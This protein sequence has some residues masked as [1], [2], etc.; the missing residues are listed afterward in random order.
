MGIYG[1]MYNNKSGRIKYSIL[2][3]A[4]WIR[5]NQ[6]HPKLYDWNEYPL[7]R[8][9]NIDRRYKKMRRKS[10]YRFKEW[11]HMHLSNR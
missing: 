9:G 2:K 1:S 8:Y 10:E 6:F 7:S 11:R 5:S 3:K 4:L